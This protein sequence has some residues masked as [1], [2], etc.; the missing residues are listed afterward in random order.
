MQHWMLH[1]IRL[2]KVA[3]WRCNLHLP[4][5]P[6]GLA[7]DDRGEERSLTTGHTSAVVH[8]CWLPEVRQYSCA[9]LSVFIALPH[10]HRS[11]SMRTTVRMMMTSARMA[12]ETH[13][14]A[15]LA[16]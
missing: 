10:M 12:V 13:A 2:C 14:V 1:A 15:Q 9:D 8:R 11:E 5:V 6:S 3:G 16:Q 7:C 4:V